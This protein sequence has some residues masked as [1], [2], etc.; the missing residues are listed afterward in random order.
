[1]AK[2]DLLD[3]INNTAFTE[4]K[5]SLP[6]L[7]NRVYSRHNHKALVD[8]VNEMATDDDLQEQVTRIS[9]NIS[10]IQ[11]AEA[12]ITTNK[13]TI[14]TANGSITRA[15]NDITRI[16]ASLG[17]DPETN[18]LDISGAISSAS[19]DIVLPTITDYIV[20]PHP[21]SGATATNTPRYLEQSFTL[22]NSSI[23]KA[24]A[25][26]GNGTISGQYYIR[27]SGGAPFPPLLTLH[28]ELNNKSVFTKDFQIEDGYVSFSFPV[29]SGATA[30]KVYITYTHRGTGRYSLAFTPYGTTLSAKGPLTDALNA[31]LDP[32]RQ[33]IADN[34]QSIGAAEVRITAL[35]TGI[36]NITSRID[37]IVDTAYTPNAAVLGITVGNEGTTSIIATA[38]NATLG[39]NNGSSGDY[40]TTTISSGLGKYIY[41]SL[42][43]NGGA[44]GFVRIGSQAILY[45]DGDAIFANRRIAAVPA[46]NN[47]E[48]NYIFPG[49]GRATTLGDNYYG[50]SVAE[51]DH[52]PVSPTVVFNGNLP[53]G[54]EELELSL[55]I[56]QNGNK[57]S[58]VTATISR[59]RTTAS[60][61][62]VGSDGSRLAIAIEFLSTGVRFRITHTGSG[63]ISVISALEVKGRFTKQVQVAGQ[64]ERYVGVRVAE[65]TSP[66]VY[67]V[68]AKEDTLVIE[69]N[70][71]GSFDTNIT[72]ATLGRTN[73]TI[74]EL[75]GDSVI[76]QSAVH[77]LQGNANLPFLGMFESRS[78]E[79]ETTHLSKP[80]SYT[81]DDDEVIT[82]QSGRAIEVLEYVNTASRVRNYTIAESVYKPSGGAYRE[83]A[84]RYGRTSSKRDEYIGISVASIINGIA[85]KLPYGVNDGTDTVSISFN[86]TD[87]SIRLTTSSSATTLAQITLTD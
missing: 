43:P 19:T 73:T 61:T 75:V 80:P 42:T 50:I 3:Y 82:L 31:Q 78:D 52:S 2:T 26:G 13:G 6:E 11:A 65:Y 72:P 87:K 20:N 9:K 81:N 71:F 59:A 85:G 15:Q 63:S 60:Q 7:L 70:G 41:S 34:L 23:N 67:G 17:G 55:R 57:S 10:D 1:M 8:I 47:S 38:A 58:A 69:I 36:S 49:T 53:S 39:G 21:G 33:S 74:Y 35:E 32:L 24:L 40:L 66:F 25:N 18:T 37:H 76:T 30:G 22:T 56:D 28:F 68:D 45:R 46:H 5:Q 79:F 29:S 83:V 77:I 51:P 27:D 84:I 14:A 4:A 86:S 16:Y 12:D 54:N 48:I 62:I 64:D 44:T